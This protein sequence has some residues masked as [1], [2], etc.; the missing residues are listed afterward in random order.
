MADFDVRCS[1]TLGAP[2]LEQGRCQLFMGHEGP[3]AVVFARGNK[4]YVRSW[5]GRAAGNVLDHCEGLEQRPWMRGMP[6]PAWI[7]MQASSAT[8]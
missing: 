2:S 4:R 7:E 6:T 1:A 8:V 3:H 5:R